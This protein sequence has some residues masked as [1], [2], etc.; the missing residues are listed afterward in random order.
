MLY[1]RSA[2]EDRSAR[3]VIRDEALRLFAAHG[4]DAVTVR[5]IAAAAGVS[6][7][8]VVHHF[9][10]KE[11]LREA[12]D[13]YVLGLFE[14]LIGEMT[15]EG[16]PD[17]YDPAA[18]G[19]LAEAIVRHLPPG[20]PVPGYLR[21]LLLGDGAAGRQLFRR[22]Y[23]MST[24]LVDSLVRAGLADPGVRVTFLLA[25]DL[26]V[27][28]LREHLADVLGVDPLSGE[29]MARWAREVLTIYAA[30][31]PGRS[32]RRL[33]LIRSFWRRRLGDDDEIPRSPG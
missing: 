11:G 14:A 16:A 31:L 9:G 21:R 28:L 30:G 2:E 3:A 19:S 12:V 20:S 13:Q 5:P 10:S 4:P 22:L 18:T 8:L 7:A 17:L 26:A 33:T 6:P 1:M 24:V 23:Q 15:A 32:A 29:G 27:L 25:N